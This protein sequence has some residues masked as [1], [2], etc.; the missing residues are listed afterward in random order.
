MTIAGARVYV[1]FYGDGEDG[2]DQMIGVYHDKD[3]AEADIIPNAKKYG[4]GRNY[5]QYMMNFYIEEMVVN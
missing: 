3:A 4:D 5:Q 1:L 2:P